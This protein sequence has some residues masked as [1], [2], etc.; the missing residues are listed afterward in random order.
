MTY[1][2]VHDKTVTDDYSRAMAVIEGQLEAHLE[3]WRFGNSFPGQEPKCL[4]NDADS[5]HLLEL[6]DALDAGA[7]DDSQ[8]DLLRALR[9]SLLALD[10]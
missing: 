9:S 7:L 5:S 10:G 2:R 6:V 8:R 1:A 4:V 3:M